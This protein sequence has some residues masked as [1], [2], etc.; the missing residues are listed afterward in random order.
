MIFC[1][2][3][4]MESSQRCS[5]ESLGPSGV[6]Q[7]PMTQVFQKLCS[8]RCVTRD[9]SQSCRQ[10][11]KTHP[12]FVRFCLFS[13]ISSSVVPSDST[14]FLLPI[15]PLKWPPQYEVISPGV[16]T[17]AP[18]LCILIFSRPFVESP[19]FA[20]ACPPRRSELEEST[21]VSQLRRPIQ[22]IHQGR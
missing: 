14:A 6:T 7:Q 13:L 20:F 22:E 5:T 10:V 17:K 9:K 1:P 18:T 8:G 21:T 12:I 4:G 15:C 16:T 19:F 11:H 2:F 3:P